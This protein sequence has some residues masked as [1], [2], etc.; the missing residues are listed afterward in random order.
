M[1]FNSLPF[2]AFITLFF[3]IW[4]LLKNKNSARWLWI[5]IMSA[6]FYGW[7]DWRFIF[8]LFFTGA[9][10][11]WAGK[12]ILKFP[13]N[14]KFWLLLSLTTNIGSLVIFKYSTWLANTIDNVFAFYNIHTEFKNAIPEFTL[15]LPVGI[16]FYTFNS[17]SYTIDLYRGKSKPAVNILHFFAFIS[18][19]PHLVA[20]PIIR[21]KDILSQLTKPLHTNAVQIFHGI[22]ICIWGLFQKMVLADN[23]AVLVNDQFN[24]VSENTDSAQWWICMIAF[25]FQIYF[26]FNGYSTI[27][28]GIAKLCGIHFRLNFNY[29]YFSHSF[30]NFW[31]RWH[32]S[33]SS[34]FRDYVYISLGGNKKGKFRTII[35]LWITMLLSGLWHGANFTFV[36][37]GALHALYL[38]VE[39]VISK[40]GLII[41]NKFFKIILPF[42]LI[43][44]PVLIAWTF[45]RA[46]S[47]S[48]AF[49]IIHSLFRFHFELG[50]RDLFISNAVFWLIIGIANDWI[51]FHKIKFSH[52]RSPV[53][54]AVLISV[55][56][57]M[58]IFFRGP[59][60]QFIYFQF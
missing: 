54:Q 29:P 24:H 49:Y 43:F 9:I 60:Q 35:N 11:Y 44:L 17:M 2:L 58:I 37:W 19:F 20:G 27:A 23:I 14:K 21:A 50:W 48:D 34:F 51:L 1:L 25:A 33:L 40:Q 22:R 28:R 3:G 12:F 55:L 8:L 39:R 38:T 36:I 46:K 6:V 13:S 59:E 7:W 57:A 41:L 10:D 26:D 47:I 5:C 45:F 32:I 42:F 30:Q 16:S 18:F 31:K 4:P 53:F 15:I 56:I 52:N